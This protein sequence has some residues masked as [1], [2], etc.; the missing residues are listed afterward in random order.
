V[1]LTVYFS[2]FLACFFLSPGVNGMLAKLH[3]AAEDA[4]KAKLRSGIGDMAASICSNLDEGV[5]STT[6]K[7]HSIFLNLIHILVSLYFSNLYEILAN[8]FVLLTNELIIVIVFKN[9]TILKQSKNRE[10]KTPTRL[11][12]YKQ[13]RR[14]CKMITHLSSQLK[15]SLVSLQLL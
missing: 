14:V 8:D 7:I 15:R 11:P 6:N 3:Q 5:R 9:T 13:S 4:E 12:F 1:I 10:T 2:F